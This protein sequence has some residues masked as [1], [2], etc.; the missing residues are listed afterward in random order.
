MSKLVLLGELKN[1]NDKTFRAIAVTVNGA[2]QDLTETGWEV[3]AHLRVKPEAPS[4]IELDIDNAQLA[5][6]RVQLS[7]AHD[8]AIT[9]APGTYYVDVQI[10][11]PDGEVHT[12]R[13]MRVVVEQPVTR[14][15]A[16]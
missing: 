16:P 4:F 9:L 13:T 7:I 6:S 14:V 8:D 1:T 12:S 11:N 15:E 5:L 10:T 2:T 3:V